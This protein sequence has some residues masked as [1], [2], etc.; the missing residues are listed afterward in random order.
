MA[1]PVTARGSDKGDV[2]GNGPEGNKR[3]TGALAR[4]GRWSATHFRAI[5]LIWLVVIGAFG[6][7]AVRVEHALAG[8]GWQDST[9]QSVKARDIVQRD[10]AGLGSTALQVVV[11]DHRG[12]IASSPAAQHVITDVARTLRANPDVSTVTLPQPGLSLS[13]DGR[14][15]IVTAGAAGDPNAMV[16]AAD[17]LNG[18]LS[19]L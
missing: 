10:F 16:T 7:F 3:R 11:V 8:A 14:T 19:K 1:Q 13:R 9:S 18:Q 5:L 15:A 2:A 4:L 12:P 6:V 17:T